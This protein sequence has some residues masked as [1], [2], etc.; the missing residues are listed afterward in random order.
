MQFY[1]V[2]FVTKSDPINHQ[3]LL[4]III[5]MGCDDAAIGCCGG[6][7]VAESTRLRS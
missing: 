3:L 7:A 6:E 1:N 5:I 4:L 2:I